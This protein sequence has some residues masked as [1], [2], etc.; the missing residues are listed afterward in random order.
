[1]HVEDGVATVQVQPETASAVTVKPVGGVSATVTVP[2]VGV[3]PTFAT[4]MVYVN[5][6][7]GT[8]S[9]G[10]CVFAMASSIPGAGAAITVGSVAVLLDVFDSPPPDTTAVLFTVPDAAP[11]ATLVATV[12]AG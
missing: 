2:L 10:L 6:C 12:I 3:L 11:L 9:C 8:T 4:A 5:V 7:P 1:M